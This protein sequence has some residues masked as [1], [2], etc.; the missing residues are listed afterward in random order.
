MATRGALEGLEEGEGKTQAWAA[1]AG[2][3]TG[4]FDRKDEPV[5]SSLG[6]ASDSR[7]TAQVGTQGVAG[8]GGQIHGASSAA[9]WPRLAG[10]SAERAGGAA[11]PRSD[12][13][14]EG[15]LGRIASAVALAPGARLRFGD[16]TDCWPREQ[17]FGFG[18]HWPGMDLRFRQH[19][20]ARMP[21]VRAGQRFWNRSR[22]WTGQR[23]TRENIEPTRS[24]TAKRVVCARMER[25]NY[26]MSVVPRS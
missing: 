3:P 23:F 8:D 21:K 1:A 4:Q 17:S 6:C 15:S 20:F 24:G 19:G 11:G 10:V 9:S 26:P 12:C 14:T 7:R 2:R 16:S 25:L 5:Q 13:G 18:W 22:T